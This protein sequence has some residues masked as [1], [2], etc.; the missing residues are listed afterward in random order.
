M[1]TYLD[2]TWMWHPDFTEEQTQTA[3]LFVHF[4]KS[5]DCPEEPPKSLVL[6]ITA[7]TRYKLFVNQK[8][9]SFGPV[10][11]DHTIWFFDEID[12]SQYLKKG[13][14]SVAVHV[15]RFFYATQYSPSFPRLGTGGLRIQ[16]PTE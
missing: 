4:R 5:I 13:Q 12:I 15:L 3:G 11:G 2:K 9:V 10:K 14:N 6:H 16:L 8:L 7:D 1:S